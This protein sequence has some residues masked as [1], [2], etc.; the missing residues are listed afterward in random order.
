MKMIV[1]NPLFQLGLMEEEKKQ[2]QSTSHLH[3]RQD[4]AMPRDM[5]FDLSVM[6]FEEEEQEIFPEAIEGTDGGWL[7]T[8]EDKV[9]C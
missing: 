9:T 1:I 3:S 7:Q 5:S 2:R 8:E 6:T 4:N